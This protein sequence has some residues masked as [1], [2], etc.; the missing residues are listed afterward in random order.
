MLLAKLVE[1]GGGRLICGTS[2][3]L[4]S[5]GSDLQL[6]ASVDTEC[7]GL[8]IWT[9]TPLDLVLNPCREL[10]LLCFLEWHNQ[11][12]RRASKDRVI[13]KIIPRTEPI[14]A[15]LVSDR[16]KVV[17]GWLIG[18]G[19]FVGLAGMFTYTKFDILPR[20]P[21]ESSAFSPT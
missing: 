17:E 5:L 8:G 4:L 12:A 11:H 18:S 20:L 14:T 9:L 1:L 16:V 3:R 6:L 7:A 13:T 10:G 19:V 21:L 15:Q 2:G